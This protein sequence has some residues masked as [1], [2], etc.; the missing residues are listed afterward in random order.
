MCRV[1]YHEV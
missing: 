1:R